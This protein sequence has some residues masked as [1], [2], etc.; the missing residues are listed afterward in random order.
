MLAEAKAAGHEVETVVLVG[1]STRVPLGGG[2]LANAVAGGAGT[3]GRGGT[4]PWLWGRPIG[5]LLCGRL[6]SVQPKPC[7]SRPHLSLKSPLNRQLK[8][9]EPCWGAK[10]HSLP[11]LVREC[12][13]NLET[14][15]WALTDGELE[16]W[17]RTLGR[18]ELAQ[19]VQEARQRSVSARR[20]LIWFLDTPVIEGGP[21]L[22]AR[23]RS[24]ERSRILEKAKSQ[25][26]SP[27][28]FHPPEPEPPVSPGSV[29]V[30]LSP[31]SPVSALANPG[32]LSRMGSEMGIPIIGVGLGLAGLIFGGLAAG[33]GLALGLGVVGLIV[34]GIGGHLIGSGVGHLLGVNDPTPRSETEWRWTIAGYLS[35]LPGLI[36]CPPLFGLAGVIVGIRNLNHANP[37]GGWQIALAIAV[38]ILGMLLGFVLIGA[39][40]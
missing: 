26:V 39:L 15:E 24:G 4:Q 34:G 11:D 32:F 35:A 19:R 7:T 40:S 16:Q 6:R 9:S 13:S 23:L 21:A 20:S 12:E 14:L 36:F 2:A 5:R 38:G 1:G 29:P 3:L 28:P 22:A 30:P 10:I 31:A 37:H 17:L 8:P 18:G 33:C 25:T 27:Q